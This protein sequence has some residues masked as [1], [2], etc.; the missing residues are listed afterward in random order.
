MMKIPAIAFFCGA[1]FATGLAVSGMT[2][3]MK[4]VGFL[5]V[6]GA[7]DPSLA[8]V[9]AAALGVYAIAWQISQRLTR[10]I[11]ASAFDAP[12]NRIIDRRLLSGAVLFGIGWGIAGFCP[13]PA[14]VSLG[15]FSGTAVLFSAAMLTGMFA[16]TLIQRRFDK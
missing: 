4:V 5:D 14:L 8:F 9:M 15:S 1:V 13:G 11:V 7:W 3:P 2:Q 12:K 16:F 6:G 10:P